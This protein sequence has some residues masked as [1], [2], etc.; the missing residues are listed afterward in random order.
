M[1]RS[2]LIAVAAL[3]VVSACSKGGGTATANIGPSSGSQ[4]T[5]QATFTEKGGNVEIVVTVRSL[6]PGKHG[7]HI[8]ENGDCSASNA[9]SAG[10][11]FNPT[12]APHGGPESG[13]HH[14]GDLGNLEAGADGSGTLTIT[15]DALTVGP[16]DRSIVGR[17]I[18]IHADPDDL[19]A[20]DPA[21][22][23]GSRVGCGVIEAAG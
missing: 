10:G 2:I 16:G 20:G 5:G 1:H 9:A 23:S 11:H 6:T 18:V 19:S 21:G 15:T 12:G 13:Q 17:S 14:A 3:C 4:V 22:H 8:H 7:V